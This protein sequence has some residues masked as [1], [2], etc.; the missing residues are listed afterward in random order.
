M[1]CQLKTFVYLLA[2]IGCLFQVFQVSL[3]YFAYTTATKIALITPL[4]IKNNNLSLCVRYTDVLNTRLLKKDTGIEFPYTGGNREVAF[5]T[6]KS[7]EGLLTLGQIFKYTPLSDTI[8]NSCIVR[9]DDND[10]LLLNKDGCMNNFTITRYF[11]QNLMCYNIEQ[12]YAPMIYRSSVTTASLKRHIVYQLEFGESFATVKS[13]HAT[14]YTGFVPW[15]SRE[16]SSKAP[17]LIVYGSRKAN[18][19]NVRSHGYRFYKLPAPYD[20]K[21]RRIDSE[22]PNFCY[23]RCITKKLQPLGKAATWEIYVEG[24]NDHLKP[25]STAELNDIQVE[26][27]KNSDDCHEI[28]DITTCFSAHT[29]TITTSGW[30]E[31]GKKSV[32]AVAYNSPIDPDIQI[33]SM[34]KMEFIEFIVYVCSCIGIWF[35]LS[36][37]SFYRLRKMTVTFMNRKKRTFATRP[38]IGRTCLFP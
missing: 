5:E 7:T 30:K 9:P 1:G 16:H 35:G 19:L 29:S 32:M 11:S 28:C 27:F 36:F 10:V 22:F 31:L 38:A 12:S 23:H 6:I 18:I 26:I 3:V 8:I 20:T 17:D 15:T 24:S 21:C 37:M 33:T 25:L 2:L 4:M 14:C 13:V 34:A